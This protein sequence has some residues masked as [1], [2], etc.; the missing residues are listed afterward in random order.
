MTMEDLGK[1][2][3]VQRSAINKYEKGIVDIKSGTLSAIANAL[4]ISP[5]AL[6][7][8]A[9]DVP[10]TPEARILAKGI[11]KMP[12]EQR[13]AVISMMQGLYPGL[14]EKGTEEDET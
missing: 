11:D 7:E 12:S 14:F 1:A 10:R 2:I 5:V 3:G 13:E 8:D 4:N 9:D 6:L